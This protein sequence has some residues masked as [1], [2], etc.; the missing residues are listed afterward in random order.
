[1]AGTCSVD[2]VG[3]AALMV[4]F[5][6]GSSPSSSSRK[7]RRNTLSYTGICS[8]RVTVVVRPAQ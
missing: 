6:E 3:V 4:A 1:V 7:N 5:N 2:S 8:R